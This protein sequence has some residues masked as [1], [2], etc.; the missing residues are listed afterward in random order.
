MNV[1]GGGP[2][3]GR[4]RASQDFDLNL[5][6]IIDAFTVLVTFLLASSA[7]LSIGLLDAGI[8]ASSPSATH[9][10][11]PPIQIRIDLRAGMKLELKTTGKSSRSIAMAGKEGHYDFEGLKKE[12]EGL[13]QSFPTVD[14]VT[15]AADNSIEYKD[16]IETMEAIRK[17][18]PNVM[19]GGF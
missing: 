8:S 2:S 15:L 12:L 9:A 13:K 19:L 17:T 14:A 3:G 7:F 5:A 16:V 1:S 11:P 10:T 18:Q 6:P 4:G